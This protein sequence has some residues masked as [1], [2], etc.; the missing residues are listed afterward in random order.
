MK[1]KRMAAP[2]WVFSW[3]RRREGWLAKTIAI[4]LTSGVFVVFLSFVR[5]QVAAPVPWAAPK[6]A[7]IQ[8]LDD[9]EGRVLTLRA[10]EGGPFPSRFDPS[11]WE[12]AAATER[13]GHEKARWKP[14]PYVPLLRQLPD[15]DALAPAP[16][17]APG[18]PV[19]PI[20]RPAADTAPVVEENRRLAPVLYPLSGIPAARIPR[21]LPP[22]DGVVDPVMA[23]ESW[24]FLLH[25]D[26]AGRVLDCVSLAGGDEAGP[27]VLDD[28]L[29]RVSF[30]PDPARPPVWIAVGVGFSNQATDESDAR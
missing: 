5:I 9:D 11:A 27:S 18:E 6:A 19:L 14:E 10:R 2:E 25:L 7:V 28:W 15:V 17:A 21:E 30:P 13:E 26:P 3:R 16:L 12:W 1:H 4:F 29:R 22:F 24:R 8:V 23:A 20:R